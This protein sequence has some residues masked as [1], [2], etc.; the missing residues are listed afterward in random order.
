MLKRALL[1]LVVCCL[2]TQSIALVPPTSAASTDVRLTHVS[3]GVSGGATKEFI[4]I[5][6]MGEEPVDVTWW[7]LRNKADISFACL[8]PESN[9]ETLWLPGGAMASFVSQQLADTLPDGVFSAIYQTTSASSGSL[10]GSSESMRLVDKLG[11]TIDRHSWTTSLS[12]SMMFVRDDD[13]A[14]AWRVVAPVPIP[15]E[16]IVSELYVPDA[17]LNIE[18]EQPTMP[19]GFV[20]NELGECVDPSTI[21]PPIL[22]TLRISELL[23]NAPGSDEGAEFIEIE[24]YGA[25]AVIIAEL[26]LVLGVSSLK[27]FVLEGY[28][29]EPGEYR[30]FSNAEFG[31]SLVNTKGQVRLSTALGVLIDE[32]DVY[33]NPKDGESW[34]LIDGVWQYTNRPT[35]GLFNESSDVPLILP[36]VT[37][38]EPKPCAENQYRSPETNRCRTIQVASA[39]AA[40]QAGYYRSPETNRCRKLSIEPEVKPCREG[41]ERNPETNRCRTIK[42]LEPANYAVL[43]AETESR[44][45]QWFI[46]WVIILVVGIIISY[47]VF[48]WRR[49]IAQFCKRVWRFARG[50]R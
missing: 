46:V 12:S 24:N 25:E 6:N 9:F 30:I 18:G 8:E 48:E 43:A 20:Y 42:K 3:A 41:Q 29:I 36:K 13:D 5:K 31:Y 33:E 34:A 49:E 22:P 38:V 1:F 28:A 10:V 32:S 26:R 40:C 35:P 39:P 23:P 45:D 2:L 44:P 14:G 17:C 4:V 50:R 37:T 15:E 11:Y 47:A 27:E 21:P 7:C 19:D 16:G